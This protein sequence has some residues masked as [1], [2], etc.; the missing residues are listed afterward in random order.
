MTASIKAS[1]TRRITRFYELLGEQEFTK[2]YAMIDPLVRSN[3]TSVTLYQY[4]NAARQFVRHFGKPR[5]HEIDIEVHVGKPSK[6][7]SDRDFAVGRTLWVDRAGVEH[8]FQ[9]RW[10]RAGQRWYTRCTGFVTPAEKH[11]E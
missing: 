3:S 6:L 9:E 10:V 1:L 7:Y 8:V 4:E 2:C 5:V 11:A